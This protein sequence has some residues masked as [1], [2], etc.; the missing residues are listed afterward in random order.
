MPSGQTNHI[1]VF[2]TNI[3]SVF[4]KK[5]Y[6][7]LDP[8]YLFFIEQTYLFLNPTINISV[9]LEQTYLFFRTNISVF[10]T[11]ISVY[12]FPFSARVYYQYPHLLLYYLLIDNHYSLTMPT[13]MRT[14]RVSVFCCSDYCL[15]IIEQKYTGFHSSVESYQGKNLRR[16]ISIEEPC[17]WKPVCGKIDLLLL[18]YRIYL[19]NCME[20][21]CKESLYKLNT[22]TCCNNRNPQN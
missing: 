17:N 14:K 2:R 11:N 4:Q 1:S 16:S 8:A 18:L 12:F 21:S 15:Q 19:M 7:F 20:S 10:R 9:F 5:T 3:I 6:L 22:R 13:A